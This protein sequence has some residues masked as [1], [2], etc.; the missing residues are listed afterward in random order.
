MYLISRT[1]TKIKHY[2][3]LNVE[4][5]WKTDKFGEREQNWSR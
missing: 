2:I 4:G 3:L 5:Q 1:N